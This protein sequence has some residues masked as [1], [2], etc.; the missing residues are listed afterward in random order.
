MNGRQHKIVEL[1]WL[2]H[3]S[4]NTWSLPAD[5]SGLMK[6]HSVGWLVEETADTVTIALSHDSNSPKQYSEIMCIAC[7]LITKST[8]IAE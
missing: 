2:D 1:E 3:T 8:I 5:F 4:T 6:I 7:C